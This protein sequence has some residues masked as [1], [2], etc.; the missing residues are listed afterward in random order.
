MNTDHL[1][2][3]DIGVVL[4]FG[5]N[6]VVTRFQRGAAP[7]VGYQINGFGCSTSEDDIAL[8]GS[9]DKCCNLAA[10]GIVGFGSALPQFVNGTMNI[11]AIVAMKLLNGIQ[12]LLRYLSRRGII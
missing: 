3:H 7:T 6:D 9:P 10:N 5:E 1:P 12:D 2:R 11:C 4:H 8:A